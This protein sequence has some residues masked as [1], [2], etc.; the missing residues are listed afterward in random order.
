MT[1]F[2]IRKFRKNK[3]KN[4]S[5]CVKLLIY[6][7]YSIEHPHLRISVLT[8]IIDISH[9]YQNSHLFTNH[10]EPHSTTII[11]SKHLICMC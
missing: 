3:L 8:Y 4:T 11:H 6:G 9:I 10:K 1:Y 7:F 5:N 2:G